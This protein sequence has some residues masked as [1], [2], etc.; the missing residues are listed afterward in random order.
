[1]GDPISLFTVGGLA[2]VLAGLGI[3]H[4]DKKLSAPME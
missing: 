4:Y 3:S 2:L 1:M